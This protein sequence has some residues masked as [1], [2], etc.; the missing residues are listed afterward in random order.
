MGASALYDVFDQQFIIFFKM[1]FH[2]AAQGTL[3]Y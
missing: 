2:T 1:F 3:V